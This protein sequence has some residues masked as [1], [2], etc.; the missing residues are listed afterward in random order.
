MRTIISSLS[1]LF[2]LCSGLAF[3]NAPLKA[4][5]PQLPQPAHKETIAFYHK[6]EKDAK[7]PVIIPTESALA[8]PKRLFFY[9]KNDLKYLRKDAYWV[10]FDW[11]ADCDG[12]PICSSGHFVAVSTT[13]QRLKN[14]P[15][16]LKLS[17][18]QIAQMEVANK[19]EIAYEL[20]KPLPGQKSLPKPMASKAPTLPPLK[21]YTSINL[22]DGTLAYLETPDLTLPNATSFT[23]VMWVK[24]KVYYQLTLKKVTPD[25]LRTV[26]NQLIAQH[27]HA[28]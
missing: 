26:A 4:H 5:T 12:A 19:K 18:Q 8:L 16:P 7:I 22:S 23:S 3:A 28:I 25:Q 24:H 2:F 13:P 27:G 6:L 15:L 21:Y 1:V 14:A 11:A 10:N 17:P 9:Q 20:A